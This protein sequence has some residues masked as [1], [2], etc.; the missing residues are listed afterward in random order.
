VALVLPVILWIA[1]RCRPAFAAAA[2]FI[3]ALAVFWSTTFDV[4]HFADASVPLSDRILAAQTLVLAAALLALVLAALFAERRRS[5]AAL[6]RLH[7]CSSRLW[8]ITDLHEGLGEMLRASIQMMGADKGKVQIV[9]PC[10]V[11]TIAAQEGFDKPFLKFF[12]EVS[13]EHSSACGRALRAGHR[14]IIE[15]V[16]TDEECA[17][18]RHIAVTAGFRAV[19]STPLMASDGKPLGVLSTHF[20]NAHRPSEHELQI[21]DLYA[22][23]AVAFM[24]RLRSDEALRQSEERYKGIY[25]NAGTGIYIADLT[26]RFQNCNPSYASMHGYTEEELC[27]LNM[28]DVVL[29][30]DWPRHTPDIQRLLSGEISSFKIMNRC[31]TKGGDLRWVHKHVSLLRDAAGRPESVFALV[32]DMT[33]RKDAEIALEASETRIASILEIAGDAIVSIDANRRITLF[34][35]AAER[36]FGYSR[37]ETLGQNIDLLIPARLRRKHQRHIARFESDPDILPRMAEQQEVAGLHKNGEEFPAEASISKV[38]I[39]GE[40]VYIIVLRNISERKRAEERQRTLVSEL[41]HRVKNALATVSAVV[42]HTGQG[43]QSVTN[44]VTALDGRIRSMAATHEMLSSGRWQGISLT[45]LIRRELA[46]YAAS[47]NT[48][49]NGPEVV[50]APEAG[51]AMAMVLHELATNAAK[52]GALSNKNGRVSIRWDRQPNRHTRSHLVLEWQEIGG[53]TVITPGKSSYGT[54]TI[55]DLIPYEFGGTV[56]LVLAP[57][58]VCCRLELPTEWLSKD[59]EV[60][61]KGRT[62]D[63][64][65]REKNTPWQVAQEALRHDAKP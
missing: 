21:L 15:D 28:K 2:M 5:E 7:D 17:P 29:P 58:G 10:G 65:S 23:Q 37:G 26:G 42:S 61:S 38:K 46:P 6:K 50:L 44:F 22:R 18:F 14:I 8:Q 16:E 53:P 30:E 4:G 41:D 13:V 12:K 43:S 36:L 64:D 56:E 39:G 32:T 19:Q 3:V 49:I 52:Y 45:N 9:S 55:R 63:N 57:D 31:V 48:A 33:E 11:L 35:A 59:G 60:F 54:S 1:V 40:W 51:Q 25:E 24:E 34:N 62:H 27:K 47:N 20:C